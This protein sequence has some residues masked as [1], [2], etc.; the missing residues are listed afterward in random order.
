MD[1]VECIHFIV[2]CARM[3]CLCVD[4]AKSYRCIRL[5]RRSFYFHKNASERSTDDNNNKNGGNEWRNG[6]KKIDNQ[7]DLEAYISSKFIAILAMCSCILDRI[8]QHFDLL[9]SSA[10]RKTLSHKYKLCVHNIFLLFD[11]I[12]S[13]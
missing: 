10:N 9:H 5:Y 13:P 6:R 8:K 3:R 7:I 1:V 12:S 2:M 11:F 4:M